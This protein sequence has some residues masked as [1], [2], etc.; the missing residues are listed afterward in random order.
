MNK[1]NKL[2]IGILILFD[3]IIVATSLMSIASSNWKVLGLSLLAILCLKLPFIITSI[4]NRKNLVLPSNFQLITILF[5]FAAQY[6][7]EIKGFYIKLWWWDLLLHVV[8]GAYTLII[9]LHLIQGIFKQAPETTRQRFILFTVIFAFS[10]T[11]TL[12]TMW[13]MFEF[14]TDYLFSTKLVKGGL[15]DTST[16]LLAKISAAFITSIIYYYRLKTSPYSSLY[17]Y[18]K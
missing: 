14:V 16:D 15:E 12:G 4:A 18:H 13:E 7:G 17:L 10:F 6:L 5:I 8:F 1:T 3:I 2:P 9:S 11:I